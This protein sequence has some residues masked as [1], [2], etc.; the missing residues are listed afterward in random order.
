LQR[1]NEHRSRNLR[2]A[3]RQTDLRR[4]DTRTESR[5]GV[6]TNPVERCR[7]RSSILASA[8]EAH[9]IAAMANAA[10]PIAEGSPTVILR[11]ANLGEARTLIAQLAIKQGVQIT[12]GQLVNSVNGRCVRPRLIAEAALP[13]CLVPVTRID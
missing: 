4:R 1:R 11:D 9:Q 13:F 8:P 5:P 7:D 12:E 10:L 3:V 6:H 2:R